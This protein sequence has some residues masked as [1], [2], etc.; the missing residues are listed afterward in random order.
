MLRTMPTVFSQH[1]VASPHSTAPPHRVLSWA[2]FEAGA[3]QVNVL[4]QSESTYAALSKDSKSPTL[5][6]DT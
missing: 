1:V 4:E 3:A 5:V 6:Y 2:S